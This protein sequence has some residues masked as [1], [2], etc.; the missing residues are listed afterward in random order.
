MTNIDKE[1]ALEREY[2]DLDIPVLSLDSIILEL[3]MHLKREE[4]LE[5]FDNAA[6]FE[7]ANRN[8]LENI[9]GSILDVG[10]ESS[11]QIPHIRRGIEIQFDLSDLAES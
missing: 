7:T 10:I 9:I 3:G 4:L 2:D 8:A 1:N 5:A 11:L 6:N